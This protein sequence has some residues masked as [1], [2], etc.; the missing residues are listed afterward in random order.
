MANSGNFKTTPYDGRYLLFSWSISRQ[1]V[2]TNST[3]IS[4]TLQGAGTA[5]VGYYKAGAFKVVIDGKTVY[6]SSTR[7]NLYDGTKVASGTYTLAHTSDGSRT[8]KASAQGAIYVTSV[9]SAGSGTF[10]LPTIPRASTINSV[11]G[12][13][14]SDTFS[15]NFTRH[16]PNFTDTLQVGISG[17][18]AVQTIANYTSGAKFTLTD[19]MKDA[20]YSATE[21]SQS[22][23]V[24]FQLVTY[25]GAAQV[26]KSNVLKKSVTVNDSQPS[27]GS[28]TYADTNATTK[29]ITSD[30]SKVIRN[31]STVDVTVSGMSAVNGATLSKLNITLGGYSRDVALSGSTKTSQTVSIGTVDLATDATLTATVTDSRGSTAT[32]SVNV[33]ILDYETPTANITC[34]RRE[35]FYSETDLT[36]NPSIAYLDGK[37]TETIT[38]Q[39]REHGA[40]EYGST[41]AVESG[42]ETTLTLDNSKAWDVRVSVAD[43][44]ES[45][46]YVLYVEKGQPIIFFDMLKS[47]VGVNCFPKDENSLEVLGKNIYD[48]LFYSSGDS[49]TVKNVY[50]CGTVT[51]GNT[52]LDFSIQ[53]P[54]S[55]E[56]IGSI[57]ISELKISARNAGGGYTLSDAYVS[58]GY[59]V[60]ADS[61]ITVTYSLKTGTNAIAIYLDTK[62]K[63]N[64]ANN[65]PQSVQIH[66]LKFTCN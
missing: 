40:T 36:V 58:G 49:V 63:Y 60:L 42:E 66:S 27:I 62:S 65:T 14:T 31:H 17:R 12:N 43:A 28:V 41:V 25:N 35:N 53:L 10:T 8:F 7:I 22:A 38:A 59:D 39:Y 5:S 19:A 34:K 20:I 51:S 18:A 1:D 16:S 52:A 11:A 21:S 48:A 47:S 3:I 24:A 9:N 61:N 54:K 56:N 32:A 6:S 45:V 30:S 46:A 4:W 13:K 29:A 15:V 37:N 26:G 57:T 44:L 23:T 2:A 50:A 33:Q 55:L 64:G